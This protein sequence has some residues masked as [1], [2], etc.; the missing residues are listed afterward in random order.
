MKEKECELSIRPAVPEDSKEILGLIRALAAY[1][2]MEDQCV[3][4]EKALRHSLSDGSGIS[5]LLA[6]SRGSRS[7][8]PCIFTAFPR[9]SASRGS[10][11]KICSSGRKCVAGALERRCFAVWQRLQKARAA[12]GWNGPASTGIFRP[13]VFTAESEQGLCRNGRLI[14]WR[15]ATLRNFRGKRRQNRFVKLFYYDY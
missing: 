6:E 3:A 4:T 1:E 9:F 13:S 10:I 11:W 2:K 7:D 5:V 8:M 14:V 12:A 15:E